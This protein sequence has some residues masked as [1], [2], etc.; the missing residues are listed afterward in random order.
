MEDQELDNS[1]L[2]RNFYNG[3]GVGIGDINNDGYDDLIIGAY[4]SDVG[5]TDAG[6]FYIL[7]GQLGNFA[8]SFDSLRKRSEYKLPFQH[9][10][11]WHIE[12][13]IFDAIVIVQ[14]D[15]QINRPRPFGNDAFA[16]KIILD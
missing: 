15:I 5:G 6:G 4:S 7:Y 12:A 1:F 3:G 9:Q 16:A 11:M 2:F 8:T 10:N 13:I 14:Y